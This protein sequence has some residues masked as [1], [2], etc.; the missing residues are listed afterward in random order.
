ME[1][2]LDRALGSL[3]HAGGPGPVLAALEMLRDRASGHDVER[4]A[5]RVSEVRSRTRH[6]GKTTPAATL[7]ERGSRADP[8]KRPAL[9]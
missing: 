4:E 3:V 6:D 8:P 5:T 9:T 2:T 7:S 1:G